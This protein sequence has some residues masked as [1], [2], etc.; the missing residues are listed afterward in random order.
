MQMKH[1]LTTMLFVCWTALPLAAGDWPQWRGPNRDDVSAETGLL[2]QWPA[3]GPRLVWKATG[4]GAGYA[5]VSVVGARVFTLGESSGS[6][7][8]LALEGAAGHLVWTAKIGRAGADPPGPRSTPTV[9]GDRVYALGQFGDLVCLAAATGREVWRKN[10]EKDFGGRCGGWSYSESPLV[11]GERLVCTPGS[12]RGTMV[13]LNKSTG[14]LLWQTKEFTDPAEYSSPIVGQIGGV[15]QYIQLTGEHVA[16]VEAETGKL[17][18]LAPRHGQTATI[19]T[20]IC[21]D[22]HV[23]VTSG[24]GIGCN[25]FQITTTSEGYKAEQLWANQ[26]MANHHGGVV[27][28]GD[29]LYGYSENKGWVC[30][31]FNTG[32][33]LW[34]HQGVGKGSLTCADGHLYLRSE[35]GNGTLALVQA[36]PNGYTEISRFDQPDR[37][38]QNSWPH[39]VIAGGKLYLRDQDVLLCYDLKH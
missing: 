29:C 37:S 10:L 16:G 9:D 34:S 3:G 21:H 18:W 30:Q 7:F 1:L 5:G 20:P 13:A 28:L 32:R 2:T 4:L 38:K 31:D 36:T 12:T 27:R 22:N 15:R 33:L 26:V 17:L 24:Y 8:A 19:P 39:P 14:A 11:D 35:A 25:L 23:Y 6:S